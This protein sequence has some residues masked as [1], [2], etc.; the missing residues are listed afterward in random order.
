[1]F[2]P[3]SYARGHLGAD[4]AGV[5]RSVTISGYPQ[6]SNPTSTLPDAAVQFWTSLAMLDRVSFFIFKPQSLAIELCVRPETVS[7]LAHKLYVMVVTRASQSGKSRGMI[8]MRRQQGRD[9]GPEQ[10]MRRAVIESLVLA[11]GEGSQ[12]SG[13]SRPGTG[14]RHQNR[15]QNSHW[16]SRRSRCNLP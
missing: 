1:M 14:L 3:I 9:A 10:R 8:G 15:I 6:P 11:S 2:G 7:P 16:R 4:L 5:V 12:C 13:T